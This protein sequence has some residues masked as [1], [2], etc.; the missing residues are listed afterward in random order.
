MTATKPSEPTKCLAKAI[1]T[2][3][4]KCKKCSSEASC[5]IANFIVLALEGGFLW[6]FI[7]E[8]YKTYKYT[9]RYV[10]SIHGYNVELEGVGGQNR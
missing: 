3:M 8:I 6:W 4:M 9:S 5:V 10:T 2:N 7:V 1:L